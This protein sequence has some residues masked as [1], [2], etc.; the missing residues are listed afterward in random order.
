MGTTSNLSLEEGSL[1]PNF[2]VR[3]RALRG[4]PFLLAPGCTFQSQRGKNAVSYALLIV[5]AGLNQ[6]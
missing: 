4:N 2:I 6:V 5:W 3:L 1:V